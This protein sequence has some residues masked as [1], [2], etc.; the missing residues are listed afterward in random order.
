MSTSARSCGSG[1]QGKKEDHSNFKFYIRVLP[2]VEAIYP[3]YIKIDQGYTCR[4]YTK[5]FRSYKGI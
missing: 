2:S 4:E 3:F 1:A 5:V